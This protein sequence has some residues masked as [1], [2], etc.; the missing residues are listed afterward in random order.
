LPVRAIFVYLG[1]ERIEGRRR[2]G[3][4]ARLEKISAEI[5]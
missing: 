3:A 4:E 2:D 5:Y 1:V